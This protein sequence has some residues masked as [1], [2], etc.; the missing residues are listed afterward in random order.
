MALTVAVFFIF[1]RCVFLFCFVSFFVVF[2]SLCFSSSVFYP[3]PGYSVSPVCLY[4]L[5]VPLLCCDAA[6]MREAVTLALGKINHVAL[7]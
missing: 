7:R 6:D 5:L 1:G 4:K 3:Y 2:L